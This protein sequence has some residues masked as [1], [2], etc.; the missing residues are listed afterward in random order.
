MI[1]TTVLTWHMIKPANSRATHDTSILISLFLRRYSRLR[2][3]P[4]R[5]RDFYASLSTY[6]YRNDLSSKVIGTVVLATGIE[7]FLKGWDQVIL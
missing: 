7:N 3:Y 2:E 5:H 6:H 1:D 4:Y